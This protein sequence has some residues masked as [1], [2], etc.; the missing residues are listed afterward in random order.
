MRRA[1]RSGRRNVPR[2][3][4]VQCECRCDG[5]SSQPECKVLAKSK[6]GAIA[7]AGKQP[8][9]PQVA[10]PERLDFEATLTK[11]EFATPRQ[12]VAAAHIRTVRRSY[13]L[14]LTRQYVDLESPTS[15]MAREIAAWTL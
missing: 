12:R 7:P 4:D 10:C 14:D 5:R 8:E 11:T 6:V 2:D 1:G 13:I 3:G 15:T 9:L